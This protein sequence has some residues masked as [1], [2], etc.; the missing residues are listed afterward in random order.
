MRPTCR[1]RYCGEEGGLRGQLLEWWVFCSPSLPANPSRLLY[2]FHAMREDHDKPRLLHHVIAHVLVLAGHHDDG[3]LAGDAL[4]HVVLVVA[5][6]HLSCLQGGQTLGPA[7]LVGI[8]NQLVDDRGRTAT[9]HQGALDYSLEYGIWG[10]DHPS[11]AGHSCGLQGVHPPV[12]SGWEMVISS[13]S[14]LSCTGF[15]SN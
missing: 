7:P 3:L 1:P 8:F 15:F 5:P 4:G 2:L 10:R 11:P 6:V 9:L 13:S 14:P 12:W